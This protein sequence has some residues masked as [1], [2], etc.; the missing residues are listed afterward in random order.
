[1]IT[2]SVKFLPK[3]S[4]NDYELR[5]GRAKLEDQGEY[6][7]KAIKSFGGKQESAYLT[8]EREL[9]VVKGALV[10]ACLCYG[11]LGIAF[12]ISKLDISQ[13]QSGILTW[14]IRI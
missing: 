7:V 8:V 1:M 9:P 4:G 6:I 14:C 3:Y 11:A 2:P 10:A 12:V 13:Q 5:I